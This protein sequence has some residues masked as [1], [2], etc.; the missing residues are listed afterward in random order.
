MTIQQLQ[1]VLEVTKTGSVSKAARNL[2]L[3]QPNLS[4]AIKKLE[5]ELGITI[6]ERTTMGMQLT[7]NGQRLVQKAAS[8]MEDIAD[9]TGG[10]NE[11]EECSFRLVYPR[12][13]PAFEAFMDLCRKYED[14][15]HLHFSCFIG[16]REKQVEAL[17]RNLCDLA[18][19][20]DY[21]SSDFRRLCVDLHV[22]YE[23]LRETKFYIQLSE[24]HPLLRAAEFDVEQLKNYPYVAF[25]DLLDRDAY[26]VP[27]E[28]IVNPD[29]LICVQST[30]SRASLVANSNAFSIVLP[31]SEEYN[32][33]HHVVQIPFEN[34]AVTVGVLSSMDRKLSPFAETYLGFLRQ[35]M[36]F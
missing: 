36:D 12:Y 13:V 8:I 3:S 2:Y 14:M 26:W 25:A 33:E 17:Y 24:N 22:N 5:Q 1:Y 18:V 20:A 29:R 23:I 32:R 21:G 30:S 35:R 9:I 19:Y 16:D 10:M 15:P 34:N 28:E 6:F 11:E 4:N 31:H 7:G 27:W